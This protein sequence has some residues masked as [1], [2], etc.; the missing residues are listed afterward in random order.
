M[1][2]YTSRQAI[3][4]MIISSL[5][6]MENMDAHI[7]NVAIPQMA[8]YFNTSVFTL[9]LAVTS[10]LIGIAIFIPISGWIADKFGI[11][12]TLLMSNTLF[13]IMSFQCALTN[14]IT[15]LIICRF[16]QGVAGAFMVPVARVLLLRIFSKQELV[17]AYTIMGLPVMLGPVI[18]PVL[19][20]YLVTYFSWRYIFWVNVPVGLIIF[21]ATYQ[22]IDNY[23]SDQTQFNL[24]SFIFLGLSLGCFC[25]WLDICLID[26]IKFSIKIILLLAALIFAIFYYIFE[27]RSAN[28]LIRY[29]LFK[30]RTFKISFSSTVIIRAAL[31]GRA[32]LIAI[33]LEIS[34]G[35]SAFDAGFYFIWMALGVLLSRGMI[36]NSIN[37][38]GF[39]N[40]LTCANIGGSIS[41]LAFMFVGDL[42][43]FL[44]FILFFNGVFAAAQFM[45]I[46]ILYYAEV[47]ESDYASAV[48]IAATLQQLGAS[49][50]VVIAASILHFSNVLLKSE[51]SIN[52]FRYTFCALALINIIAQVFVSKLK[53][54]DGNTLL[55]RQ[56]KHG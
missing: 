34:Y 18:A 32:F 1:F 27:S 44:Y 17:R 25:F 49:F 11:R 19:G 23:K 15:M 53:A 24:S 48:S 3:S 21:L 30:L 56:K 4:M 20:G 16:A 7:L 55:A 8:N 28:P 36:K 26:D 12:N 45:T 42:G 38:F 39:K 22:Y 51:F 50:G 46:N 43:W 13:I 33:F 41:L 37:R 31:G 29:T 14:S 6:L 52:S 2:G 9:K 47:E 40:T 54:N 5:L 10:Y 35:L